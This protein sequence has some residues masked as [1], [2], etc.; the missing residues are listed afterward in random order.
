MTINK[1]LKKESDPLKGEMQDINK[2][3]NFIDNKDY[4]NKELDCKD[5]NNKG[6]INFW[7]GG[8]STKEEGKRGNCWGDRRSVK[9]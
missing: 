1:R 8:F 4:N 7:G 3:D 6:K 9:D 5:V 2:W